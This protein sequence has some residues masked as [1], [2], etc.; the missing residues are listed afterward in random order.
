MPINQSDII[1]QNEK[2]P[3]MRVS[4]EPVYNLIKSLA[5]LTKENL[6]PGLRDW[7]IRTKEAMSL[8]ERMRHQLVMIGLFHS[9]IPDT[10]WQSFAGYLD[11]LASS[12]PEALRDR[13]LEVY[14]R[15]STDGCI[16]EK[17]G[18]LSTAEK[19]RILASEESY[20][21]YL[22]EHF[23]DDIDHDLE[24]QAYRYAA[25][26]PAMKELVVGHLRSMWNRYLEPEWTRVRAMLTESVA[27]FQA[28]DLSGMSRMEAMKAVTGREPS[29]PGW[30]A[31]IRDAHGLVF[32]PNAHIGPYLGK[33]V[34]GST[35][36]ILFGARL[37]E[38][39]HVDTAPEL[40]RTEI[41]THLGA[42]A[43]EG[44]L[45]ILR[46]AADA[47]E[48][49]ATDV[50]VALDI[51]QSAASRHLT[52]LTANGY[53]IER[54]REGGK[55]YSFNPARVAGALGAVSQYLRLSPAAKTG[56]AGS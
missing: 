1:G 29:Y 36:M 42:L 30:E 13:M 6:M 9:F 52:Q 15:C 28:L 20:L 43:D 10:S 32:V 24:A 54:R 23:H 40:T 7:V 8:E 53:L 11:H 41:V 34:S 35:L 16:L 27:A 31:L 4:L 56:A 51:S 3:D 21:G 19:A 37:P 46:M 49:R 5:L 38:G 17:T 50:M 12:D 25:D 22:T 44:R 18:S 45:R 47:G 33:I 14:S 48:L 55:C 2:L 39:M 26:P